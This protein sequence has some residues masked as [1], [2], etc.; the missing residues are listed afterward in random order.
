[1]KKSLKF[2]SLLFLPLIT[3]TAITAFSPPRRLQPRRNLHTLSASVTEHEASFHTALCV[4]PPDK[5]WDTIQRARYIARDKTY[6]KWPPAIRLF[7][8]F[9]AQKDLPDV[10]LDIAQLVEIYDMKPFAMTLNKWV[11]VPH[12]EALEAEILALKQLPDQEAGPDPS[13]RTEEQQKYDKL[14]AREETIG[15]Q[16]RN[17]RTAESRKNA[18]DDEGD[19]PATPLE[20]Q[21]RRYEEFNGPCVVCL[22]PDSKSAAILLKWRAILADKLFAKYAD[23]SPSSSVA[24]HRMSKSGGDFRPLIPI[25][26]FPT[27]SS[28]V[29]M[30]RKLKAVWDPLTL[31]V[32][33]FHLISALQEMTDNEFLSES[34]E[35][36]LTQA[37][38]EEDLSTSNTGQFGCDALVSFI[39]AEMEQDDE[40]NQ[41]MVNLVLETGEPG[42]A[43]TTSGS[44]TH[45]PLETDLLDDVEEDEATRELFEWLDE[46]DDYDE[47]QVVVIGRTTFFSGEARSYGGM[48]ASSVID[49]KDR[50]L[51]DG[52]NAASRRRGSAAART[53]NLAKIGDFGNQETDFT[54]GTL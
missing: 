21:R 16:R 18:N 9:C 52:M 28:A 14:I 12:M 6:H 25:G 32:T 46:D 35:Y 15:K 43:D 4:V 50:A 41:E 47:G 37:T 38:E 20:Q 49:G 30:A 53:A 42:G 40:I 5:A 11:I 8:P 22:E 10:A 45:L 7:H 33:E 36:S 19:E 3:C 54:K 31:T 51:G 44:A 26:A 13:A 17:R 48:P 34:R 1:M 23:F 27:V 24:T 29:D 39:G 2:G